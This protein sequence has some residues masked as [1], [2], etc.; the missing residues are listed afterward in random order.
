MKLKHAHF[1]YVVWTALFIAIPL[2]LIIYYAFTDHF[3]NF[4]LNYIRESGEYAPIILKS[5]RLAGISTLICLV[6][7]FPVAYIIS[8]SKK[9]N[10]RTLLLVLMLPM[11][12]NFLLRTYGWL[13][14]LENNGI[15]NQFLSLLH[16]PGFNMINTQGAVIL[17]M[18]YNYIPFMI[19]P[20]HSIMSKIGTD[21]LEV[22][23]TKS[24]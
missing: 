2:G 12:M 8:R 1:P 10:E 20:L 19:L 11:W 9:I 18:V 24:Q 14:I 5:I 17:G 23:G 15:I 21:I 22:K 4:T 3:G 7:G 6:C 16:L 13:S